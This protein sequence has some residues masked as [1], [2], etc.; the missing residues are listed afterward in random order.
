MLPDESFVPTEQIG[1]GG[2]VIGEPERRYLNE[3]LDTSRLSYGPMTARFEAEF[4]RLHEVKFAIFCNSGT[5]A[6]HVALAVLK[7]RGGWADGDEVIVPAMTFVATANVILHNNL[8]PV[9]VDVEADTYN[10]DPAQLASC[11]STRTRAILPVHLFGQPV[12]MDGVLEFARK[13]SLDVVEDSAET[14]FARY[15]GQSVG[16]FG[17]ISCFSTYVA[18]MLVTGVG[19]FACTNDP[20]LAIMIKSSMNHGRDSIYFSIDDDKGKSGNELFDIVDRRFKF[21]RLGHSFRCTELEAAIGLGQI[22]QADQFITRRREIAA[23]YTAGLADLED[24]LQLP[25]FRHDRTHNYMMYPIV[26]RKTPKWDLVHFLEEQH[27]ETR[28]MMPLLTQPVYLNLFGDI[29]KNYPITKWVNES[30]FYIGCHP[31]LTDDEVG[32]VIRQIHRFFGKL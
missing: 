4:A 5:S 16:S 1:V 30:G 22:E 23:H 17:D 20:E 11:L 13:H 3:V 18:H 25:H 29:E 26:M 28:E 19:G 15:K 10:L 31:Y 32:Y 2:F 6:L 7:E 27:I 9:F 14:M 8:R 24:V 21:V 12:S